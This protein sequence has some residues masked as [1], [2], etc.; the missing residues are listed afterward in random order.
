[1]SWNPHWI[2]LRFFFHQFSRCINKIRRELSRN[3]HNNPPVSFYNCYDIN[4]IPTLFFSFLSHFPKNQQS[5]YVI[6]IFFFLN[7]KKKCQNTY[8]VYRVSSSLKSQVSKL[9]RRWWVLRRV[10][11]DHPT[12]N[13][14]QP[15]NGSL[16]NNLMWLH[17]SL[18]AICQRCSRTLKVFLVETWYLSWWMMDNHLNIFDPVLNQMFHATFPC[19]VILKKK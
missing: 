13:T 6:W 16:S 3:L 5:N 8:F 7:F 10:F 4:K 1:M 18:N 17:Q 15:Y 12:L 9:E 19:I 14:L 11:Y 2:L